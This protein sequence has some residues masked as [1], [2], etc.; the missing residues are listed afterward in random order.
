MS[1]ILQVT[2]RKGIYLPEADLWLDPHFSVGRAFISHAHSDHVARH[3]LTFSSALTQQI[4][5]ARYGS[6]GQ[7]T[8]EALEMRM[9]HE[10][11]GWQMRLLPA[12]H[13]VGSAMLHLT[14]LSDGASLLYTGDY[15]LRQGLSSEGCEL[16]PADTL[17]MET[18]FGLPMYHFPPTGEIIAS[19]LKWVRET[20]EEGAIPVLLGYSL[21]K[22]QEALCALSDAGYSVMVHPS[23][24]E[25]TQVVEPLLG[26]LPDYLLFDATKAAGHVLLFPPSG[27]RSL[28]LRKLPHGYAQWLGHAARG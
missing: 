13:I 20:L 14:R 12:G 1:S 26:K 21:G 6:K 3:D 22:A 9:V 23:V 2:Y 15:K 7:G 19:I 4:M 27:A 25:M 17:I 5:K 16:L 10:W 8:F 28:A 24:M 18:T 11:E